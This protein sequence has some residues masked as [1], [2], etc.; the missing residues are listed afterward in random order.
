MYICM[1]VCMYIC[2]YV[3]TYIRTYVYTYILHP[4]IV[5]VIMRP[6]LNNQD[7]SLLLGLDCQ[8]YGLIHLDIH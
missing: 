6:K 4:L 8:D 5:S 2:T 1:Y 3:H 7:I